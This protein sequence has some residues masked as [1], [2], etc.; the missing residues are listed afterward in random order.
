MEC[1]ADF[2]TELVFVR[3]FRHSRHVH[4]HT[5][6]GWTVWTALIVSMMAVAFILAVAVPIFGYLIGITASLFASFYTYVAHGN[7]ARK[8]NPYF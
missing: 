5:I 8:R 4:S 6:L 7:L 2:P 1:F 3:F